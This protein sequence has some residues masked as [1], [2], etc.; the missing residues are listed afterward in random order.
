MKLFSFGNTKLPKYTAIFNMGSAFNCPSDTLGLCQL[1]DSNKCYAKKAERIWNS[2]RQR[3]ENQ[4]N[5]WRKCTIKEFINKLKEEQG[6]KKLKYLR[7]NESG[8]FYTQN[9]VIKACNISD[10]LYPNIKSYIYTARSDLYY[11]FPRTLVIN[12]AG[13]MID[14]NFLIEDKASNKSKNAICI[15]D[16]RKCSICTKK[17]N[18][19]ISVKPH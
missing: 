3:R 10:I 4:F 2:V 14:N 6:T 19:I 12:G 17:L 11:K 1:M 16:C 5:F 13:F 8:D 9:D 18:L 15:A 7:F